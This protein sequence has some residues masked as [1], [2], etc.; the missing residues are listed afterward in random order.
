MSIVVLFNPGHSMILW[1]YTVEDLQA[2]VP[3]RHV[4]PAL[5]HSD[6]SSAAVGAHGGHHCPP[7]QERGEVSMASSCSTGCHSSAGFSS[8]GF[9]SLSLHYLLYINHWFSLLAPRQTPAGRGIIQ[10]IF[11][12]TSRRSLYRQGSIMLCTAHPW[13]QQ[14][15]KL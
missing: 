8:A 2:V 7:C 13:Q 14:E 10:N 9:Q 6:T 4:D 11:H 1:T 5:E 12:L 15:D 3:S